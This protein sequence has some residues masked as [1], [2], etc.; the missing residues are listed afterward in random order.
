M[1]RGWHRMTG[2]A[3]FAAALGLVSI[4]AHA[5]G[6]EWT[7][8]G[9]D[10]QRTRAA[11]PDDRLSRAA[12]EE[13]E[14]RFLWKA[15]FENEAHGLESL[16]EPILED[17]L[18]GY[19]G[20]KALAFLGGS[21]DRLFAIDTDLGRPYWTT[22]LTYAVT[23]GGVPAP[24]P[25]CPGGLLAAPSR[26][27]ALAHRTFRSSG[28]G[29]GGRATSRVGEAGQGA[30]VLKEMAT[31]GRT[32]PS[33][34]PPPAADPSRTIAPI[35]F[36]GVDPL[37]AM[38]SDGLLRTLRVSDGLI[39]EPPVPF[40]P[41]D[42]RPSALVYVDGYV[43]T[44]T[45]H[46]C[47]GAP[48][49]VWA[50]DTL[51]RDHRVKRWEPPD[52]EVLGPSGPTLGTDGTL[53]V[54]LMPDTSRVRDGMAPAPPVP[55]NA[56][57]AL[58]RAALAVKDWFAPP[59]GVLNA[60]PLVFR[61][62]DHDIVA[63]T[64]GEG[65]LYLL[66]ART[67]GGADHRTAWRTVQPEIAAQ[68]VGGRWIRSPGLATWQEG[69]T[70]WIVAPSADTLTAF[71]VRELDG[72]LVVERVWRAGSFPAP[73]A[74]IVANGIVFAA[75][76]GEFLDSTGMLTARERANRSTPAVLHAL[77]GVTGREIWSS[78]TTITSFARGGLSAGAGQV[79][80]VTHDNT[81]YAFGIPMEH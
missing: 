53:Y 15:T 47:G 56:L 80:V 39:T 46:R 2:G 9:S 20:F 43:Y 22:H 8:S 36:G 71:T 65:R 29:R 45:S 26:R 63:V 61:L 58:D 42:S 69:A 64:G 6:R 16:T 13:G 76:S 17:R 70:R 68:P 72:A 21:A 52:A 75:A 57:V 66:D 67:L 40:L 73:L 77:E 49:A 60:A 33:D 38:G 11:Q 35:P 31:R 14:F 62:G 23:T 30:A 78:G 59:D 12:I 37:Y 18:I 27:T 50:L 44:I 24:T 1:R 81:L 19:R 55:A 10:A 74:P 4:L 79:Y 5:Q 7:T 3:G 25:D 54:A 32:P 51:D 34:P 41:P 28:G 48:N